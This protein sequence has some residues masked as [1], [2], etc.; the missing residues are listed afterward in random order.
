MNG[1]LLAGQWRR[2]TLALSLSAIVAIFGA[3]LYA[4]STTCL[5]CMPETYNYSHMSGNYTVCFEINSHEWH[6]VDQYMEEG[7]ESYWPD[8]LSAAGIDITFNFIHGSPCEEYDILIQIVTSGDMTNSTAPAEAHMTEDGRGSSIWVNA[9]KV[10]GT[11]DWYGAGAHEMGH[12]MDYK[13]IYN[14]PQCA[15]QSIMYGTTQSWPS[16]ITCS[17]KTALTNKYKTTGGD[18]FDEWFPNNQ[19]YEIWTVYRYWWYD[20]TDYYFSGWYLGS[21]QYT[22]CENGPPY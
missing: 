7:I 6:D 12:L 2:I 22:D 18:P 16:T 13:D 1:L 20:G 9:D 8:Y 4:Q 5:D 21:Y 15:G 10:P 11:S 19:C 17:D 3:R 14:K